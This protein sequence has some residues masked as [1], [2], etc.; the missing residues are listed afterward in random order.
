[1]IFYVP[2]YFVNNLISVVFKQI[3]IN[4]LNAYIHYY[5]DKAKLGTSAPQGSIFR[6]Q[7]LMSYQVRASYQFIIKLAGY[8]NIHGH[9][10]ELSISCLQQL[11]YGYERLKEI[12]SDTTVQHQ[13]TQSI[14][15]L[16]CPGV[17]SNS[18]SY[19]VIHMHI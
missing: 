18:V 2:T 13:F 9:A 12:L 4:T 10:S 16:S 15:I 7:N 17:S 8:M 14:F 6:L 19:Y 5:T 11:K 1:M 3:M